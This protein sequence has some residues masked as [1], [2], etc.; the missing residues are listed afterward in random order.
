MHGPCAHTVYR[1]VLP[2]LQ[3][4]ID[5]LPQPQVELVINVPFLLAKHALVAVR[6][7][8][9]ARLPTASQEGAE[10][11]ALTAGLGRSQAMV[12]HGL[13]RPSVRTT[14]LVRPPSTI[15]SSVSL[16]TPAADIAHRAYA[17][18]AEAR[19]LH[20]DFPS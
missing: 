17:A 4:L 12:A 10:A 2:P 8:R 14:H 11:M 18:A 15:Y 13:R 1:R 9:L 19:S 16:V 20:H 3:A 7:W 6:L 5:L